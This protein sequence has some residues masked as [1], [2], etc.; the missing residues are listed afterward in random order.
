MAI[1]T[2]SKLYLVF[3]ALNEHCILVKSV[4]YKILFIF[5]YGLDISGLKY[6]RM[7]MKCAYLSCRNY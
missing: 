2:M 6:V 1:A 5:G 3:Q 4:S 7:L